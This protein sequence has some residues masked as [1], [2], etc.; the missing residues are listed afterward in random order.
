LN[1][2]SRAAIARLGAKEEG[3]FRHHMITESGRLRDSVYFSIINDEWQDVKA[4]LQALLARS[5]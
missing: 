5:V 4:R 1:E 3:V 2:R